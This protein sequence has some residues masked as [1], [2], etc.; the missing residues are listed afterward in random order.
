MLQFSFPN[1]PRMR[2]SWNRMFG[3]FS[4]VCFLVEPKSLE[5]FQ[6]FAELLKG[7]GRGVGLRNVLL[8]V[9]LQISER[10]T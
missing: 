10:V 4:F 6:R 3:I 8:R 9:L 1:P 2:V 5:D 7:P